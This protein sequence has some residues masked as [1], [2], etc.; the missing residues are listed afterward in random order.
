MPDLAAALNPAQ[1]F[2]DAARRWKEDPASYEA[3]FLEGYDDALAR[4]RRE[5]L[6][7]SM[8]TRL[9]GPLDD[10]SR[11]ALRHLPPAVALQHELRARGRALAEAASPGQ[12]LAAHAL[13]LAATQRIEVGKT[14]PLGDSGANIRFRGV[15]NGDTDRLSVRYSAPTELG[16][17][18]VSTSW[19][20][21]LT[22]P[23]QATSVSLRN[24]CEPRPAVCGRVSLSTETLDDAARTR[25]TSL[26]ARR[27]YRNGVMLSGGIERAQSRIGG[28]TRLFVGVVI[29]DL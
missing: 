17:F 22:R 4:G 29:T 3:R 6:I 24:P 12:E 10:G 26:S 14:L 13:V 15:L 9:D 11:R 23:T 28:E 1:I 5:S 16:N 7:A 2:N 8:S 19:R 27:L 21:G 20:R 25:V 18:E